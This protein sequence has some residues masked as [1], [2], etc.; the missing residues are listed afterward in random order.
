MFASGSKRDERAI[1]ARTTGPP[2]DNGILPREGWLPFALLSILTAAILYAAYQRTP[3]L[4][5]DIA[6]VFTFVIAISIF[7]LTWNARTLIDNH[8]F[9]FIGIAYLYIGAVD[10]LHALSFVGV[11]SREHHSTS[12]ELWFAARCIQAL[13]LLLAP[14]FVTERCGPGTSSPPIPRPRLSWSGWWFS[15]SFRTTTYRAKDS[16]M[17]KR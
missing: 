16:R 4:A 17:Q 6:E 10:Y 8:Y 14:L 2:A 9:I 13:T 1:M 5:H 15:G 11:F 12:I 3:I 7:M